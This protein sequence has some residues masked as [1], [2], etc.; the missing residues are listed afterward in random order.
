MLEASRM[1][2]YL[3]TITYS[4]NKK[5]NTIIPNHEIDLQYNFE[6]AEQ[7]IIIRYNPLQVF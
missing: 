6:S 3:Y 1:I 4:L 7:R 5:G 2:E